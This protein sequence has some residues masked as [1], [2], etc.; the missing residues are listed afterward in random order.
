MEGMKT[1]FFYDLETSGFSPRADR[2]M[3]FAGQ[4]TDMNLNKIGEPVN[5]LVKVNDDI[6]PSPSA[7][8]VTK[9]SPQKTVEEGYT[10]AE[11]SK[12]CQEEFFTPDTIAV[13][14][15]N[16]RFDDEHMRHLFWRNFFDPYEWQWKDGRSKWDLLDVVRMVR[17]L[18][19]DGINWPFVEN[20]ET[21]EKFASNKLELLTKENGIEHKNAHDALADVDGLIEVAR[22][23]KEKQP[24]MFDYLLKMRDKKEVQKL[25]NLE[26]PVPFIYSSGRFA[27]E[28]EKT[29]VGFPLAPAPNR[30]V[31][32][33][34]VRFSPE[35]FVDWSAEQIL[36]NLNT[37]WEDRQVEGFEPINAKILNYGKCP[38]VAPLGVLDEATQKR[39]KINLEEVA[40]NIE[41][42]KKNP[43]FV[44]NL[45]TAFENRAKHFESVREQESEGKKFEIQPEEQLY[46]GFLDE[47][48][49]RKVEAVR[50]ASTRELADF[51]PDFTDERLPKLLLHYKA[52][53]FPKSLSAD[54]KTAWEAYRAQNLQKMLPKFIEE[55]EEVLKRELSSEQEFILE[56]LKLWF[57]NV[58]PESEF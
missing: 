41:I 44:E 55:M 22:L 2:I 19:P 32:I 47:G 54:E 40:K 13:G 56:E 39:L 20:P 1:F 48:D 4:R 37:N 6:L 24:K 52:R 7:L 26:N 16:I 51:H 15:N 49:K 31:L 33:W 45:R 28:F 46:D 23:I 11:F 10:E 12:M 57:E 43:H 42:L 25:I 8:M 58:M 34:D 50:N 53:S 17:A 29:S 18:R 35:K 14:Y 5:I 38:A 9:I 36:E 30:N 21:G 27:V 3:Q